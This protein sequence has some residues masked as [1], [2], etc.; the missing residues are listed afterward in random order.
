MLTFRQGKKVE[1]KEVVSVLVYDAG[2]S[3][4]RRYQRISSVEPY[5]DPSQ[6]RQSM[7]KIVST[8]SCSVPGADLISVTCCH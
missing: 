7:T 1:T 4:T 8:V 3:L 5:Q 2:L 6:S